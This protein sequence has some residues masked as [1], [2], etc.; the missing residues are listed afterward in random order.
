MLGLYE[1]ISVVFENM[2]ALH[3]QTKKALIKL[4]DLFNISNTSNV[5]GTEYRKVLCHSDRAVLD[6]SESGKR[7][8]ISQVILRS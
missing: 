6:G 3:E 5:E 1:L 8:H 7:Q 2:P 4:K